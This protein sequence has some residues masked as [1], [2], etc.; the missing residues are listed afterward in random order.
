MALPAGITTATVTFGSPVT[1]AGDNSVTTTVTITPSTNITHAATGVPIVAFTE[2]VAAASGAAGQIALPHVDQN[3]FVDQSGA[4]YKMWY[5]TATIFY[6]HT[7]DTRIIT[8]TFQVLVGQTTVDLD[9]VP[10]GNAQPAISA[11]IQPVTSVIGSTGV[12]TGG[13]IAA[14]PALNATYVR[15]VD[16]AGNPISARHVTIKVDTSTWEIAD[17]VAEA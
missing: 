8:K 6:A 10:A 5:Y 13:M 7:S 14:D 2:T 3:G 4:A 17:I 11:P 9:L 16:L 12:I 15:F 1:F